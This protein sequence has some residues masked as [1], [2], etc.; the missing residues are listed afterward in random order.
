MNIGHNVL[1]LNNILMFGFGLYINNMGILEATK[2]CKIM[3]LD[4]Q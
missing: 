1:F 3:T 4:K 2:Y